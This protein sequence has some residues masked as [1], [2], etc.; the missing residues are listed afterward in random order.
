MALGTD[1]TTMLGRERGL[2]CLVLNIATCTGI[3]YMLSY[4]QAYPSLP[5]TLILSVNAGLTKGL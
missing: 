1:Q 2:F 3:V 4:P 5:A